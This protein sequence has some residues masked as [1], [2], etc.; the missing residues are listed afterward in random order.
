MHLQVP[1]SSRCIAYGSAMRGPH[2]PCRAA[3]PPSHL[4]ADNCCTSMTGQTWTFQV[5]LSSPASSVI[6]VAVIGLV[7]E[8]LVVFSAVVAAAA[9]TA[10]AGGC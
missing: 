2:H 10:A 9:S 4:V 7:V 8:V 5:L 3:T 1:T 6:V